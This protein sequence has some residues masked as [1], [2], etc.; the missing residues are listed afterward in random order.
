[1]SGGSG[2]G[3]GIDVE[4]LIRRH[5]LANAY[6]HGGRADPGAVLGKV[7]GEH[8][9]LRPRARELREIAQRICSEV[10]SM[11]PEEQGREL[12]ATAPRPTPTASS[13]WGPRGRRCYRTTTPGCTTGNSY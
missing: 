7:L 12:E 1:M 5:A 10:S 4:L 3:S 13:T 9:E 11:S 8:P 6:R 2:P